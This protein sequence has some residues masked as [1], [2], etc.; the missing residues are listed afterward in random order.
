MDIDD[1]E[2]QKVK[3]LEKKIEKLKNT[4][5]LL[6]FINDSA[7]REVIWG[8]MLPISAFP[9]IYF[10]IFFSIKLLLQSFGFY[11]Y[12]NSI[13]VYSLSALCSLTFVL[14]VNKVKKFKIRNNLAAFFLSI[15]VVLIWL[16]FALQK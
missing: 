6:N 12:E 8:M 5:F 3:R 7:Y 1:I 14:K 16:Y 15:D 4:G 10:P 2:K 9:I 11:T 13:L